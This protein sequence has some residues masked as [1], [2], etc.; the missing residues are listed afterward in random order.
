MIL[1]FTSINVYHRLDGGGKSGWSVKRVVVYLMIA[2]VAGGLISRA[3]S[4]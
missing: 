3:L 4:A 2:I 1:S